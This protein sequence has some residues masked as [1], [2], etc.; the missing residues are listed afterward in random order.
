MSWW[1]FL[2]G[3]AVSYIGMVIVH[4]RSMRAMQRRIDRMRNGRERAR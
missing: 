2:A 1:S 3:A 4:T